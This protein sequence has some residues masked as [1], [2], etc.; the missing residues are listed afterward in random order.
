MGSSLQKRLTWGWRRDRV[1]L[2]SEREP[3]SLYLPAHRA[4]T[5]QHVIVCLPEQGQS[6]MEHIQPFVPCLDSFQEQ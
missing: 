1:Q 4:E 5:S 2:S 6:Y 3:T